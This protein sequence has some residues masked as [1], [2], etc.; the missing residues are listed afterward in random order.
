MPAARAPGRARP[1]AGPAAG[2][3]RRG[4]AGGRRGRGRRAASASASAAATAAGAEEEGAAGAAVEQRETICGVA[5]GPG[6]GAV[7]IVRLSGEGAVEVARAL[8]R[9]GG[10]RRSHRV[11]YGAAVDG[12]GRAFDEV[13]AIPMLSPRSYT[14][15]DVVEIHSHGGPVCAERV[16]G[17]CLELGAR[18][19]EPGEFTLRAF[20][21]G[22]LDLTQ[23]EAVASLVSAQT[24]IAADAALAGLSGTLRD[25]IRRMHGECL[26]L[27]AEVE[28]HIDFEGD[29]GAVDGDG[30]ARRVAGLRR[31]VQRALETR[32]RGRL[33]EEG[34]HVVLAGCPNVGKS[35]LLNAIAEHER[36]IVTDIAGTTRDT[37]HVPVQVGGI[38]MTFVDTAGIR[39]TDEAVEAIGVARSQAAAR[40]A[41]V[42]LY[43]AD[44]GVDWTAADQ[45]CFASVFAEGASR[46]R[47]ILVLNKQDLVAAGAPARAGGFAGVRERFARTVE[48]SCKEDRGLE[49]LRA[50]ILEVTRAR[51]GAASNAFVLNA[52][53]SEAM[54]RADAA[55]AELDTIIAEG[56]PSDCW[57]VKLY[58]A[59]R[60]LDEVT[61]TDVTEDMLS[62]V[63]SRFCIGK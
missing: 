32:E 51:Q 35:S 3:A 61:G 55:L 19:A 58:D 46:D 7:G 17:R 59:I 40:A 41:D 53:Q 25:E 50:A 6:P 39:E 13:L 27:L 1:A 48:T 2:A 12:G 54:L 14:R 36:A 18:L 22:R 4:P 56:W 28:A 15:E 52:R 34:M 57:G 45:R 38:P 42:V 63:F 23:A 5:T 47:S 44:A 31:D 26:G 10:L 16:L 33:L 21:N 49:D 9:G 8:F 43:V 60:A 20:L 24:P 29:L 37:I 62:N 11:Y 30:V